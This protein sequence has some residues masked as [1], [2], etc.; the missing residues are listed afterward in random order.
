MDHNIAHMLRLRRA[1]AP[2]L[3]LLG[4]SGLAFAATPATTKTET[5]G[6]L[7]E[8]VV[9]A[10]YRQENLQTTP[11][12]IT[13]ITAQDIQ[14]RGFTTSTDIALAVPNASFRPAQAAFGN[15]L[16][17]FIRGIGQND[18]NFAF[19]PGV[20]VYV[21]DVY[22]PTVMSS[23]FDLMDLERVEVL[24][25]PQGTL[26]GRGSI[27]GA[28]RFVSKQPKGGD[29]GF[30]EATYGQRNHVDVRAG[31]DFTLVPD[32]FFARITGVSKKQDGYQD[33][34]DFVCAF[35]AKSG[36]L[37]AHTRNRDGGCKLGTLGGTD[38]SGARLQLRF[39]ASEAL[40]LGLA[41]DFQR[42]DSEA[43]ADTMI[44]IVYP[45]PPSTTWD[46]AMFAKYGVHYDSR[47][48]PPNP[49]VSYA[50]FDD[51]YS[52]LSFPPKTSLNQK[53]VS[54]TANWKISDT[55]AAKLILAW[56]NWDSYFSTDQ[57]GSPLG[58]SV[59]DG[60]ERFQYR[61]AELQFSGKAMQRLD[62]TAGAFVYDGNSINSQ[63]V[64]LPAFGGP[65]YYSNPTGVGPSGLP[66][67]L[68]V[69]GLDNGH[70]ENHSVFV[71]GIYN[72]TDA[73]HL[74]LGL[75][76]SKDKKHDLNDN[77]IVKQTVDTEKGRTDWRVGYDYQFNAATMAYASAST[78]YR[79][80]AYNP[81]PFQQSQFV[82]VNGENLVAY[83][84]GLKTDLLDHRLRIN[85]AVFYT[86][87]KQR[88]IAAGGVECLKL[89]NGTPIPG[90]MAP[91]PEGGPPCLG[92]A[93]PL[94]PILIPLTGYINAPAKIKGVELEVAYR[95]VDAL[96]I[97]GSFGNNNY[98]ATPGIFHGVPFA[99][100]VSNGQAAYV[101]K[102]NAS[103]SAAWTFNLTNGA[104]LTPRWD[105]YQQAEICS[106][107][108][109][110]SCTA[111]YTLH[112]ARLEY[113]A[114][115]RTWSAALGVNNVA[116]KVYFLN[117]FDTS[118]FGE[119]T[120]EGQPGY[121]REWFLTFRHEFGGGT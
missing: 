116:N 43:R 65:L 38:V 40:E 93:N 81:R 24:R 94:I 32:Q 41:A 90:G 70:F 23:Q 51:P 89:P 99:G 67:A 49:F 56:R 17:A 58:F 91:N 14:D 7:E 92:G 88:I 18:F 96:L 19:E 13:A 74:T 35:P 84:L 106:G 95:P 50:T 15:T 83:E 28:I 42:D 3:A 69:N 102:Y 73:S 20:G 85:T 104:T 62:W 53:G 117:T 100:T 25:G 6:A 4:A 8:V 37:P 75:R 72:L 64:E 1:L 79:P 107:N 86:D 39:V 61:T 46:N 97:N 105:A 57:D 77:T 55:V 113:A 82:A 11:L 114:K 12:A 36:T 76:Y 120:I 48:L 34:I 121:P 59:V 21:D 29:T 22:Y 109:L 112:N 63:Q 47:F 33:R 87:Y 80:A 71:H 10:E 101:P 54:G 60:I 108:N 98:D 26:F 27:G 115:G 103:L 2:A 45:N 5:S 16:T 9:T 66:N 52:G 31:F 111:A 118:A 44:G 30:V 78:G 110:I 119:P 68:L